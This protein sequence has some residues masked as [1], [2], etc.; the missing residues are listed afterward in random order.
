MQTGSLEKLQG[1]LGSVKALVSELGI[2]FM[3]SFLDFFTSPAYHTLIVAAVLGLLV[4]MLLSLRLYVSRRR[5]KESEVMIDRVVDRMSEH[6]VEILLDAWQE[7]WKPDPE[8]VINKLE[9]DPEVKQV[10]VL[11]PDFRAD[12]GC[13][14]GVVIENV[15]EGKS[16]RYVY[17]EKHHGD[18]QELMGACRSHSEACA[19]NLEGHCLL[20]RRITPVELVICCTAKHGE[21]S[22]YL[23]YGRAPKDSRVLRILPPPAPY[24]GDLVTTFEHLWSL[25][26]CVPHR[27]IGPKPVEA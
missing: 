17:P 27:P 7:R 20:G 24:I 4:L 11:T 3:L 15:C 8:E 2:L 13:K 26:S 21:A 12:L 19:Q 9:Q 14:K 25:L 5:Q 10:W 18:F 1:I 16:Y 22:A 23:Y 6:L